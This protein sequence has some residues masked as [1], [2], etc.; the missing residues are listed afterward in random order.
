MDGRGS[1]LI[2]ADKLNSLEV[3][4]CVAPLEPQLC[5]FNCVDN[6]YIMLVLYIHHPK[7]ARDDVH[8]SSSISVSPVLPFFFIITL[9]Y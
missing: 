5:T 3:C 2:T 1:A 8:F 4:E 9:G 7:R 6:N